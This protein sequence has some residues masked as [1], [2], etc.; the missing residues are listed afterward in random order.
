MTCPSR[1]TTIEEASFPSLFV[2]LDSSLGRWASFMPGTTSSK[3]SAI[4]SSQSAPVGEVVGT[5]CMMNWLHRLF[6][7]GVLAVILRSVKV[8]PELTDSFINQN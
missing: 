3:D 4:S 7:L 2:G 1:A 5:P 6:T 8:V